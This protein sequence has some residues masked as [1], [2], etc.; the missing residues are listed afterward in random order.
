MRPTVTAAVVLALVGA[1]PLAAQYFGQNKVQYRMFDFKVIETEHFD[2][3]Y[4]DRERPAALDAARMAERAYGRLSRVMHHKFRS[5]KPIILYASQSDFAQT[6]VTDASAEGLGGVTEFF[7]HRMV[8]PF[9]GSYA[10]FEHVLQ[11]EM[12]H[13]F[14]YDVYSRGRPGA[15][16]QTLINV[17]PPGWFIEGMAEYLSIGPV[18]PHTTMWLRDAALEGRLPTIEQLSTNPNIFPYRF[19]HA[20]WAYIGER[21]GDEVVGEILEASANGGIEPALRRATGESLEDLSNDW[22]DA[23]QSTYLPQIADHERAR[24]IARPLLTRRRT[25]GTLNLAPALSPDGKQIAFFSERTD[26]F[27]DLWLADAETGRVKR[28][29][30]RSAMSTNY[31][32]LRFITASGAFSPDG[33][34]YALTAKRK[35]K[36]D[37]VILD[38]R[39]NREASRIRVPLDGIQTPAWSPDG[40][41]LVFTGFMGGLSDLYVVNRDGSN[42][43]RLTDD[44]YAEL[45]PSWSPD[46]KLIAFTTDRGPNTDFEALKFGNL[47]IALYHLDGGRIEVLDGMEDGKNINSKWAPDGKSLAFVSDR[48]GI[49]NVYL[50]DFSDRQT[51]QI[52]DLY[53]GVSGIGPLS[54]VLSWAGDADRLAFAYYS[55]G[56][57]EVYAVDN[58]RSLRR[59]PYKAADHPRVVASLL[60]PERKVST[61]AAPAVSL[62]S[63]ADSARVAAST[64]RTKDGFRASGAAPSTAADSADTTSAP[65]SIRAL[66][67]SASLDLPDTTSFQFHP[68]RVRYS[69]DLIQRPT[70][71][72]SRDNF[73]SGVTGG[74]SITL[75][76][77]L[78]D[79]NLVFAGALNGRISEAQVLGAYI[80]QRRRFTWA[81]G[82]SQEP[83][84]FYSPTL[85]ERVDLTGQLSDSGYAQISRLRRFVIRQVFT[86]AFYPF[87]R[88]NRVELGVAAINLNDAT[89]EIARI[90]NDYNFPVG[91]SSIRT[92]PGPT[93]SYVQP[94]LAMAHDRTLFGSVGPFAGSRWR[95]QYSPAIGDWN[96]HAGT[97]DYRQYVFVRPF[98]LAFRTFF[99]GRYG[100]EADTFPNF[101]GNPDLIRGYTQGSVWD[102]ECRN[103]LQSNTRTGCAAL[104]QLIGS[105]LAV[106][107]V[108]LRFPLASNVTLLGV[109]LPTVH[110][111]LF[112]DVGMTWNETSIVKWRRETTDDPYEVRAPLRS[113]GGS[114]RAN[115][116]GLLIL[117][118]DYTLPLDRAPEYDQAYWTISIGPTF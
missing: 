16:I 22:H 86:Q 1:S 113:W 9:T 3:Y 7:K 109:P 27:V 36:D 99:F 69:T 116:F 97:F 64:Y 13:Q 74:S 108:E 32:S 81:A 39:R 106:A 8:L 80:N 56:S 76:D 60:G 20:I 68:Y 37:L 35:E 115:V 93:V 79:H 78:G 19:G 72:Y 47:R 55:R 33:Q 104:D 89:L 91:N 73:G 84:Y 71:G 31:E 58:P 30:A 50:Y 26:F 57:Y 95:I 44:R 88:F 100:G 98:T 92:V 107:N 42:L 34:F 45:H 53:T 15:G 66:M 29:L 40:Q 11:H 23:V 46:G 14:Q 25:G 70:I 82:A 52:T 118:A 110:G 105:K 103:T 87:N 111:A 6:N 114:I 90:Y 21:W 10:D 61:P 85:R 101:L 75:S 112:F 28:R 5:R 17:N 62:P 12:V 94:S 18:D 63:P 38:L 59:T 102:R 24:R 43:E 77:I 48:T 65:L 4:Y 96:F 51:Y 2:V 49:S 67:D 54:P 41:R 83:V 117:R